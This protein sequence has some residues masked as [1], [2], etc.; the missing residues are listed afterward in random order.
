MAIPAEQDSF[1]LFVDAQFRGTFEIHIFVTPLNASPEVLLKFQQ[2]CA[3]RPRMK[4]LYLYLVFEHCGPMGVMQSSRYVTGTMADAR[5]VCREDSDLLREHGFTVVREKIEA[6]AGVTE[7]VPMVASDFMIGSKKHY[8]EYHIQVSR[9]DATGP[10]SSEDDALLIQT[11]AKLQRELHVRVPVSWNAFK[12]Q[13]RFLNT[14][15]YGTGKNDSDAI[16]SRITAAVESGTAFRVVK[17]IRE[18]IAADDNTALDAGWL[19]PL[20][21]AAALP[22]AA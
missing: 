5:R 2:T 19:E 13:Q 1:Q 20:S 10:V 12:E 11:A 7:G 14:R 4:A 15:T 18:Y 16:V 22:I 3:T 17:V 8:F 21:P 9:P 6:V